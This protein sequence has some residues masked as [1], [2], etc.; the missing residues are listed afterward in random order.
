MRTKNI[1][2]VKFGVAFF[3]ISIFTG[4]I[5]TSDRL[6]LL[7][8]KRNAEKG[9]ERV[10]GRYIE[11]NART[12]NNTNIGSFI[13][14]GSLLLDAEKRFAH[15]DFLN[16]YTVSGNG[17]KNIWIFGDSWGNGIKRNNIKSNTIANKLDDNFKNIRFIAESSWS[18]LLFTLAYSH[19]VKLYGETPDFVVFFIDQTDIGDDFCRYRPY[20]LR[21]ESSNLLGVV[22]VS[23][24]QK[25][26]YKRWMRYVLLKKHSSGIK[27]TLDWFINKAYSRVFSNIDGLTACPYDELIS[28]QTGSVHSPSGTPTEHYLQYFKKSLSELEKTVFKH[29][30]KTRV[31]YVTHDWA[32]HDLTPKNKK[33]FTRNIK[34]IVSK[35]NN[36][37]PINSIHLHVSTSDY[38]GIDPNKIYKY[39]SDRFSHLRDSSFLSEKISFALIKHFKIENR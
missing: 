16:D 35:H 31:L 20:V 29:N 7:L 14:E 19:R 37:N 13:S 1:W 36:I 34:S 39:P 11:N 17:N 9:R 5:Y 38:A 25:S 8:I 18:P 6:L 10:L 32:Q 21:D 27:L 12:V 33:K 2:I 30:K 15:H 28:W 4:L 24:L 26:P 3:L 22:N 23:N